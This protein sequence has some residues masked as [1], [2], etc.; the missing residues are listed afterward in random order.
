[1]DNDKEHINKKLCY[2]INIIIYEIQVLFTTK[3][4]NN[5]NLTNKKIN[6]Q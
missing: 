5:N 2:K 1:M 4:K 3:K 6:E